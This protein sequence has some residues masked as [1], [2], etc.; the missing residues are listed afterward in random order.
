M[1]IFFTKFIFITS[2]FNNN[3]AVIQKWALPWYFYYYWSMCRRKQ[4]HSLGK[5]KVFS[6]FKDSW[7]SFHLLL[8]CAWNK[9][10]W[11]HSHHKLNSLST[12]LITYQLFTYKS[13]DVKILIPDHIFFYFQ[14]CIFSYSRFLNSCKSYQILSKF[15]RAPVR[16]SSVCLDHVSVCLNIHDIE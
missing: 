2:A 4:P 12:N 6:D 9:F 8:L 16:L 10:I 11:V 7:V 15:C 14:N 3:N 5:V 1:S 13:M